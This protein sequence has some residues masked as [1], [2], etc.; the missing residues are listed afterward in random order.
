MKDFTQKKQFFSSRWRVFHRKKA[1]HFWVLRARILARFK[2]RIECPVVAAAARMKTTPRYYK[3]RP[4]LS[5]GCG[6]APSPKR[7][8]STS[9]I[10]NVIQG[11]FAAGERKKHRFFNIYFHTFSQFIVQLY[12]YDEF[13]SLKESNNLLVSQLLTSVS[14]AHQRVKETITGS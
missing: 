3:S 2:G 8:S 12:F 6:S 10:S 1:S 14:I 11:R 4:N 5:G 13:S 9:R 7:F